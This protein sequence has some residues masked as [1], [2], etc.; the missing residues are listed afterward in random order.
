FAELLHG[1]VAKG[2]CRVATRKRTRRKV[3][4]GRCRGEE[5]T[6]K[7]TRKKMRKKVT[8]RRCRCQET[9]GIFFL[10]CCKFLSHGRGTSRSTRGELEQKIIKNLSRGTRRSTHFRRTKRGTERLVLLR[11]VPS[12]P[13]Y[14][15][16]P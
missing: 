2:R 3:A 14:Q 7:N 9:R 5:A 8:K 12:R 15:T 13:A 16:R 11:S 4:K 1:R 10:K 6:R